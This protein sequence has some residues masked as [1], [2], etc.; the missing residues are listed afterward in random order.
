MPPVARGLL[1][2]DRLFASPHSP[3]TF[4]ACVLTRAPRH[5]RPGGCPPFLSSGVGPGGD[6]PAHR[7]G[8]ADWPLRFPSRAPPVAPSPSRFAMF[9]A[10]HHP[11]CSIDRWGPGV[12][13]EQ[14]WGPAGDPPSHP[15]RQSDSDHA[16]KRYVLR[17]NRES[18][19][20]PGNCNSRP[21]NALS[22][23]LSLLNTCHLINAHKM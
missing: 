4:P 16:S 21:G 20:R 5:R 3:V 19:L 7:W 13:R 17:R 9:Q 15:C 2:V 12:V 6:S 22:R 1:S 11:L 10:H 23:E 18:R 14:H 8:G